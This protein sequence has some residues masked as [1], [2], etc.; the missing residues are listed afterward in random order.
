MVSIDRVKK[1]WWQNFQW[2]IFFFFFWW[3]ISSNSLISCLSYQIFMYT[4]ISWSFELPHIIEGIMFSTLEEFFFND[5][6]LP[7]HLLTI[8]ANI[9]VY[10]N[11]ISWLF[12]SKKKKKIMIIWITTHKLKELC[13]G[14]V[15]KKVLSIFHYNPLCENKCNSPY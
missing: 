7:T 8:V 3:W 10:L 1:K 9:H 14:L 15:W 4:W 11:W 2:T 13:Y 5:K 6:Y 12:F